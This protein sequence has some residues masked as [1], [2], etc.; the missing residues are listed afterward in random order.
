MKRTIRNIFI[1]IG[2]T[3]SYVNN[4]YSQGIFESDSPWEETVNQDEENMDRGEMKS[5]L[6]QNVNK[7][8]RGGVTPTAGQSGVQ[9]V[10]IDSG[11]LFVIVFFMGFGIY[12]IRKTKQIAIQS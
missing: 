3:F 12:Q 4:G 5:A 7:N 6:K 2:L 10:P 1:I 9:D 8:I 11:I